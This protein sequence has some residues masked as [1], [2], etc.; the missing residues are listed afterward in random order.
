A[1][2]VR[3]RHI[4]VK[5]ILLH[6]DFRR[7]PELLDAAG[8]GPVDGILLD[9]G[10]SSHQLDAAERG[11]SFRSDAILDMRMDPTSGEP[12]SELLARL[13]RREMTRIFRELGEERWAARI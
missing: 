13:D 7:I 8:V 2:Q 1:A 12:A 11:F 4:P 9:L 10:V 5:M 6:G 3:L